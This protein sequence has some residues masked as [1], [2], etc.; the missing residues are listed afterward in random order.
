MTPWC[1]YG[2]TCWDEPAAAVRVGAKNTCNTHEIVLSSSKYRSKADLRK[3]NALAQKAPHALSS[4]MRRLAQI[5]TGDA[6]N[7][8]QLLLACIRKSH[9]A[10]AATVG[11]GVIGGKLAVGR[12]VSGTFKVVGKDVGSRVGTRVGNRVGN[13]VGERVVTMDGEIVPMATFSHTVA[14]AM[15]PGGGTTT[16]DGVRAEHIKL[17]SEQQNIPVKLRAWQ[18]E[19]QAAAFATLVD[20]SRPIVVDVHIPT[21]NPLQIVV[22]R[23]RVLARRTLTSLCSPCMKTGRSKES[24]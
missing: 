23:R 22:R 8:K 21:P 12:S 11:P 14:A 24:M 2:D 13:R 4:G 7:S 17:A 18:K 9:T 20:S 16:V 1:E 3:R 15:T 10:F 6:G 19:M 5:R